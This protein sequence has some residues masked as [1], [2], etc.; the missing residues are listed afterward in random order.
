MKL[1]DAVNSALNDLTLIENDAF[2]DLMSALYE[3]IDN[4]VSEDSIEEVTDAIG[5]FV[6]A[7]Y[8]GE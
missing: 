2:I 1:E 7:T 8:T 4:N 3:Q 6:P 5:E